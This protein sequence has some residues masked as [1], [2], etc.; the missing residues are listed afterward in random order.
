MYADNTTVDKLN[1]GNVATA[2]SLSK[3]IA[4]TLTYPHEVGSSPVVQ[5]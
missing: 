4:S 2:S 3:I 5:F 1:P